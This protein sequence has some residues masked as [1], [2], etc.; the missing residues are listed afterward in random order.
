MYVANS[1]AGTISAIKGTAAA[2]TWTVGGKP[3]AL[4]VDAA[5]NLLYVA[6]SSLN[7]IDILNAT[8]GAVLAVIPTSLQPTAMALN[9]ATHY[10]F[11][12]C[13]GA[14][15]SV[16]V[17]DGAHKQIVTTVGSIPT[18]TTSISV[19]P[20]TNVAVLASPTANIYTVVDAANGYSVLQEPGDTGADPIATAYDA[21]GPGLF[22]VADTGDGNI[23]FADG[24]GI[25]TLGN[26]YQ[27]QHSGAGGLAMNPTTNQMGVV[28]PAGFGEIID[29][30]NPLFPMFY[31][32]VTTGA[33]P[34]ALA[35]DPLTNRVF[36]TK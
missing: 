12:A 22:F 28:Y 14:S 29:L 15:G 33:N 19:D 6:D 36:F 17:I 11:V 9:V 31:H 8:T 4:V 1:G 13:T 35:F 23:F 27:T 30:E 25:V 34:T 3:F 32:S 26:A 10:L 2:L 7:Q 18:G 21:G 16:V 20:I 5:L 24:T